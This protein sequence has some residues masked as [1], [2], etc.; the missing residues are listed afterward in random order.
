MCIRESELRAWRQCVGSEGALARGAE[1]TITG[2]R[3]AGV[4]LP[5]KNLCR[6]E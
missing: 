6:A 5:G 3:S 4:G 1:I 2:S